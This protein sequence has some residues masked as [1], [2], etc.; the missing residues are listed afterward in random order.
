MAETIEG[1]PRHARQRWCMT[2]S[3][4]L[5]VYVLSPP[6]VF[7]AILCSSTPAPVRKV[8]F[9]LYDTVYPPIFDLI[10]YS[11]EVGELYDDYLDFVLDL[12]Y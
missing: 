10:Y 11:E 1:K 3:I 2:L 4:L 7:S 6:W 8:L 12:F 5:A 9:H